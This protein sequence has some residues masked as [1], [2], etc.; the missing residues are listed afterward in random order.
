MNIM[1]KDQRD[2]L[3]EKLAVVIS[4]AMSRDDDMRREAIIGGRIGLDEM[5][6]SDLIGMAKECWNIEIEFPPIFWR[7]EWL[8]PHNIPHCHVIEAHAE[9]L[10]IERAETYAVRSGFRIIHGTLTV[11]PYDNGNLP[12]LL[13]QQ[14]N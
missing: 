13:Q 10:A 5:S 4:E 8:G 11:T 6:D 7:A 12:A 3:K 2:A 9:N 1:T 14:A